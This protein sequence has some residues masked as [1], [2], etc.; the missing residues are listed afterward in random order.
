MPLLYKFPIVTSVP[1]AGVSTRNHVV[2]AAQ[3]LSCKWRPLK[4]CRT[5]LST[6]RKRARYP[7]RCPPS[8]P[9][10]TPPSRLAFT[11]WLHTP[12]SQVLGAVLRTLPEDCQCLLVMDCCHQG[13]VGDLPFVCDRTAAPPKRLSVPP[14]SVRLIL[15]Q[16]LLCGKRVRVMN[17]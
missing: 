14:P 3:E 12:P 7:T 17:K 16:D 8:H 1:L 6:W 15:L 13:T 5:C 2:F 4:L 10:F 9:A 11:P